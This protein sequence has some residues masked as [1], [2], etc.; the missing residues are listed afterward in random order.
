MAEEK[1][2]PTQE[3]RYEELLTAMSGGEMGMAKFLWKLVQDLEAH[4]DVPGKEISKFREELGSFRKLKQ[5]PAGGQGAQGPR[6]FT[7]P[8][9]PAGERGPAGP[10]GEG[11]IGPRGPKGVQGPR[12]PK[13]D[14]GPIG[15]RGKMPKHEWNGTHIRF[16]KDDG[17][18][19]EF[20]NIQGPAG[21]H[22]EGPGFSGTGALE[23]IRADG[24]EVQ[25][26]SQIYFGENI[27]VTKIGPGSIRIDAEDGG[28]GQTTLNFETPTGDIDDSNVTFEVAN[29]PLYLVVNGAQYFENVHYTL[30]GLTITLN[31]PIGT[32]GFIR[33]AYGNAISVET[34]VGTIDDSNTTFTV[35][36]QPKYVVVNGAQYFEGAGYTYAAGEI[37]L[38]SP[39]GEN[40][41]IRSV[42]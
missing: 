33:S 17:S 13:G 22:A 30:A 32:G 1:K 7:G 34:P 20:I 2:T 28:G 35:G 21:S 42:Y 14:P 40:G 23:R 9:G 8:K 10:K 16:Q 12:G 38:S 15:K 36:H 37:D 41:F 25:G 4:A 19:G 6:G 27:T 39:V 3:E 18:W 11:S 31:D 24:L 29:T 5:G 26:V